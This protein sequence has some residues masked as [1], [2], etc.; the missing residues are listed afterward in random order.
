M[1]F[2]LGFHLFYLSGVSL[3]RASFQLL[4]LFHFIMA[5]YDSILKSG[6]GNMS[7]VQMALI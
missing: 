3:K 4:N 1:G 2:I 7:I 6:K 5:Y